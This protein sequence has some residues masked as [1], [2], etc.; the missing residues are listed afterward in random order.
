[1]IK[2]RRKIG[3]AVLSGFFILIAFACF[4]IA[5]GT[6]NGVIHR[7]VVAQANKLLNARVSVG[8][9]TG[10]PFAGLQIHDITVRQGE[11]EF[12]RVGEIQFEYSLFALLRKEIVIN[13]FT[14]SDLK[15]N[16]MQE[17]DSSWNVQ[18]LYTLKDTTVAKKSGEASDI[19]I[20]I[21]KI[22]LTRFLAVIHPLDTASVIP[23]KIESDLA[24]SLDYQNGSLQLNMKKM[25]LQSYAPD[26]E[27]RRL[28][29]NFLSDSA[30]YSWDHFLLQLPRTSVI[31][32]GKYFPR[33][34]Q[35][36]FASL[37]IDTLAFEHIR[38]IFPRFKLKGNPSVS[39]S[40]KMGTER[41]DFSVG[42]SEE[43]QQIEI[44]GWIK[45]LATVP[46]YAIN[47][48]L[49]NIDGSSWTGDTAFTS[50][51]T[52]NLEVRGIGSDPLKGPITTS[53]N[54]PELKFQDK[55]L[56]D[57]IFKAE[58]DSITIKGNMATAAWFG[59]VYADFSIADYLTKFR[60][61]VTGTGRNIDLAKLY[62]PKS[63]YS[64]LNLGIKA[65][66]EGMN[67]LKGSVKALI[68]SSNSTIT[69]RPVEDFHTG[70]SYQNGHYGLS[71]LTLNTPYFYLTANG[72][73]NLRDE[74]DFRFNFR[75]KD[76]NELLKLTGYGQYLFDGDIQGE[77]SGSTQQYRINTKVDI[78]RFRIDSLIIKNL[79]GNLE[80]GR[81]KEFRASA[82]LSAGEIG[83][84]SIA[85]HKLGAELGFTLGEEPSL[86]LK[87]NSDSIRIKNKMVGALKGEATLHTD[88]SLRFNGWLK[89]D[90]ISYFNI[91]SGASSVNLKSKLSKGDQKSGLITG[92]HQLI[93]KFDPLPFKNYVS[94][95]RQDTAGISGKLDLHH[96]S[97]DTLTISKILTDLNVRINNGNYWGNCFVTVDSI[98]Y[99]R[100]KVKKGT[101]RSSFL[102]KDFQ[103]EI[104][105]AI[106]DS[107][108]GELSVD[109]SAQKDL[110]IG[111]RHILLKTP[112]D[113][114]TGGS[115]STKIV[116]R[117]DT[118]NFQNVFISAGE[119][120]HIM[121]EGVF[122]TKGN[123]N[124]IVRLQGLDLRNINKVMGGSFP[125][126][127]T[128][129]GSLKMTGTSRSPIVNA[130]INL[131]NIAANDQ[132]IDHLQGNLWY[133][134]DSITFNANMKIADSLRFEG[135]LKGRCHFS[136]EE[137]IRLPSASDEL[138]AQIKMNH[139]DLSFLKP[140]LP[141]DLMEVK[142]YLNSDL[143][144]EGPASHLNING[145]LDW[146][147]GSFHMPEYGILY[148]RVLLKSGIKNDSLFI[149]DFVAEA[150]AGKLK[151][152]G[153][154]RLNLQDF[155]QPKA[156][157]FKLFGKDFKVIDTELLQATINTDISLKNEK[158]HQVFDGNID[159]IRSE[160]NADAFISKFSKAKD[161]A[162]PPMLIKAMQKKP[163]LSAEKH[164]VDTLEVELNRNLQLY[165]N[166]KGRLNIRVP[167]NL[168]IRG[169]D[170]AFEL[171]G[172]LR[173]LKEG[174]NMT[175]YG[176][177]EVK[178]GFF[179]IYG[180]R[181][182]FRSG[183]ITLT[184]EEEVNPLLDFV[185]F[186][187]FRDL[188]KQA[189]NLE[190]T[191][192]GRL[193]E[194]VFAYR[195]DGAKVEEQDAL[196]IILFG[197]TMDQLSESQSSAVDING[198]AIAK[199][200]ALGQM[201]SVLQDAVQSSIKLDV[202]EI[203]GD[204]DWAM[205]NVIIGKYITKDLFLKYQYTFALDKKTKIIE[206]QKV[207]IE[208]QLYKFLSLTGTNQSPN[209]GIDFLFKKDFK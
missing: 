82:V 202:V 39:V 161:A 106:S 2:K 41:T 206:P 158:E 111:I 144:A 55:S 139:L 3:L 66:G 129:D 29:F 33:Q 87:I 109:V 185:V 190:M 191:I 93:E 59:D 200:M 100:F 36:S 136:L 12:L 14:I 163:L 113:T 135:N 23:K 57:L 189:K 102:N 150:G 131:N 175:L 8:E 78:S 92:L 61:R 53:G 52:G 40:A 141:P 75:T 179:R 38:K 28:A 17:S 126:T 45:G 24:L 120:K 183:K 70:F 119:L 184:G 170:M 37:T 48:K 143:K 22:E 46:E 155:Y 146:K 7:L 30:S 201:S 188:E 69:N 115:D 159:V 10:N 178:Q 187:A 138:M 130:V 18:K 116:Y 49:S 73:G 64:A 84:D 50:R 77:L 4:L 90:T 67:P 104:N 1:M 180:K 172:D 58:I 171:K 47:L 42:I 35:R 123:E 101:F 137:P 74:N 208:Y 98:G 26:L 6:M 83:Y 132:K 110:E 71:D 34:L 195:M 162:D 140:F 117:K 193:K 121:G 153:Y 182:D 205:G 99:N 203:T 32:Q 148:D 19:A 192:T 128:L 25:V 125:V 85:F 114:W 147:E 151:L 27:I 177:L 169:K 20:K 173:A 197:S 91:R 88:D 105:L 157:L 63:L 81:E 11:K 51:I 152:N 186:Y 13:S 65:E 44:A 199:N 89:M 103:N 96:F 149:D 97:Y 160:A 72:K 165:K 156:V 181:F 80:L 154:T 112:F 166:L 79:I 56:K 204:N 43:P 142:G 124:L 194:P 16:V 145:Y 198:G 31:S 68:T 60:Y 107:T 108:R 15:I 54:F 9:L 127:G 95:I 134:G 86:L 5:E 164:P 196:S 76:F 209:S 62:F 167:S 118:L 21:K 168:W 207:S 176:T 174:V 122:A 94:A 133:S